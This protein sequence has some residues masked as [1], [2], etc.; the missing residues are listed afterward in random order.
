MTTVVL[1]LIEKGVMLQK[2]RLL[3]RHAS[4][5]TYI[6]LCITTKILKILKS[7]SFKVKTR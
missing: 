3:E 5:T 7:S 1:H 4:I 6:L 2:F